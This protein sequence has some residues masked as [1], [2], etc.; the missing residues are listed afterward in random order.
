MTCRIHQLTVVEASG[1]RLN[2]EIEETKKR[3]KGEGRKKKGREKLK[4]VGAPF[5]SRDK[6]AR[7]VHRK[8][9]VRAYIWPIFLPAVSFFPPGHP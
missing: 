2:G 6:V 8:D 5:A 7:S 3:K 1:T 4:V 9:H